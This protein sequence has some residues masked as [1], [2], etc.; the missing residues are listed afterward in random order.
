MTAAS[1]V[2]DVAIAGGG[3]VGLSLAAALKQ[4]LGAGASIAIIDPAPAPTHET[5]A[6]PLR[7][8][9]IAEG[10]R[11]LLEHVRVWEAIGPKAQPILKMDIMDGDV[12]DAV[13]L[14]HL[15]F[16]PRKDAEPLAHMAFTDDIVQAL[17]TL[18][19]RLGVARLSASVAGWA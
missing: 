4:A 2:F 1:A 19:E 18:C 10:P 6:P 17:T 9:A 16:D 15:H 13:R 3:A 7:A 14:P 12:R 8:V 5:A 11:R